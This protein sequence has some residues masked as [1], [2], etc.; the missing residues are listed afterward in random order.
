MKKSTQRRLGAVTTV[1]QSTIL[2]DS[3]DTMELQQELSRCNGTSVRVLRKSYT[4]LEFILPHPKVRCSNQEV[5]NAVCIY[6]STKS[7]LLTVFRYL[8]SNGMQNVMFE[9]G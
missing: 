4:M 2:T 6:T 3:G 7:F 9:F 5:L 1:G 8:M